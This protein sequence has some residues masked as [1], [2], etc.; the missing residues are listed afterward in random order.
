[1]MSSTAKKRKYIPIKDIFDKLPIEATVS[2]L[3]FHAPT[4]SDKTSY[5][6]N[7]I[8]QSAWK[9]FLKHHT[10]LVG[11]GEGELTDEK[12]TAVETFVC[13]MYNREHVD[14]VHMARLIM[15]SKAGKPRTMAPT[16]DALQLHI[17]RVHYQTL[18]WKQAHCPEPDLPSTDDMGWTT[19]GRN[20]P[21]Y[22]DCTRCHS[23]SLP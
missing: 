6:C 21:A 8:Q 12:L 3:P 11:A 23:R 2:I 22:P 7:H 15:F 13:R 14:S 16:S 1:M 17:K 10:L 19:T 9:V 5:I 20:A 4:G 18:V